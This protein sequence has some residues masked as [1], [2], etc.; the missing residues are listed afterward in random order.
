MKIFRKIT[1][2]ILAVALVVTCVNFAPKYVNAAEVDPVTSLKVYNYCDWT[3]KYL[4]YFNPSANA[5]GY[6]VFVDDNETPVANITGSGGYITNDDLE[7]IE[8][9]EHYLKVAGYLT[10]DGVKYMSNK[11][12]VKF[13]KSAQTG[14]ATDIPQV[15]IK[16]SSGITSNYF[17]TADVSITIA[18][19]S[20]GSKGRGCIDDDGEHKDAATIK[21]YDTIIDSKSNIKVR[22][23]TS[24]GQPKKAWN[25]KLSGK[26]G[27]LGMPKGKKWCLLANS[28][29]KSLMRDTLSYNFGLENGVKYTSQSRYV[30]VYLNGEFRGN[31]QLCEP[32][33]A[34]SNRVEIDAYEADNNDI[35]LEVGTRNEE[36]VDHF[37]TTVFN[38]TFD[39]N[40]P[41]KG[42]DLTD[43]QVDAKILRARSFLST[44]E[45]VLKNNVDDL[46]A[47]ARYIDVDSFVDYYIANELFK[48]VDFNFSSTRFYI[49]GNKL[50]AGPM[51]DLDL[52]SGNCKTSFYTDYHKDGD[53]AKN[54]YC[55]KLEWYKRLFRNQ[56]FNE[57]V[58]KRFY[59]LQ[60][61]IQSL[62]RSDSTEVNSIDYLVN[63]YGNSF[64]R[65]YADK[66]QLGAGWPL[67]YNDGYSLAGEANWQTWQEPIEFLRNWLSRRNTWMCQ[68]WEI[69]MNQ[70]YA[71]SKEWYEN[72]TT[73]APTTARPTTTAAPTTTKEQ[74]PQTYYDSWVDTDRNL[75]RKGTV[76]YEGKYREGNV[77]NVNDGI[78]NDWNNWLALTV[79]GG[80]NYLGSFDIALDKVYDA[81]T[82][83]QVVVYWRTADNKFYPQNYK[84]QFGYQGT[85]K[86]VHTVTSAE[87]PTEGTSG[88]W[89]N[90]GRFVVDTD[91]TKARLEQA[92]VDSI[93]IYTDSAS[94]YG[95][96][97]R[98]V[99]VFAENPK[100]YPPE[101]TTLEPTTLAPT[102][103]PTEPP[104]AAPTT[105]APTTKAP[106]TKPTTLAP[107]TVKPTDPTTDEPT[108]Q[109]PSEELPT[110]TTTTEPTVAPTDATT[111]ASGTTKKQVA[112]TKQKETYF[113]GTTKVKKAKRSAKKIRVKLRKVKYADGYQ[114]M[115]YK[116][117]ANAKAKVKA[118][119]K[120]YV[121]SLKATIKS[122]KIK[123]KKKYYVRAR[124]YMLYNGGLVYGDWSAVKKTK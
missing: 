72:P 33:E 80:N 85:Y 5:E 41:E 119:V 116:T 20:D 27:I 19:Q 109:S 93:R 122:K 104:T 65:N 56:E 24:A 60:Y 76:S 34:K 8:E 77:E 98:E 43:D 73:A 10:V 75:A 102:E 118:I 89:N 25:F 108:T 6:S 17:D 88:G 13:T 54:Y 63:R 48:N 21:K 69:D 7:Q 49:K 105:K 97:V 9:G 38:Q 86:T 114:V 55:R 71:D 2:I 115:I 101:T 61:K 32:V 62:Y 31:Y 64:V 11:A 37:S 16:T 12:S 58:A 82:I 91:F 26:T 44:F 3:G 59:D 40:D 50:Y 110:V 120:K 35:L 111:S 4:I 42:D 81:S 30:D 100:G 39:V 95:S 94:D 52:S 87:Y 45:N 83:D 90:N 96:Q 23:N 84:V 68:Q 29:D 121:T 15:Y 67:Q 107:T 66:E 22:G 74:K 70:A 78:I 46:D 18:D 51:W 36:G 124:A 92:G 47:I 53:S 123:K 113:L 79:D 106:T 28:M 57:R 99:C 103:V 117:K 1:G 112:P 14:N